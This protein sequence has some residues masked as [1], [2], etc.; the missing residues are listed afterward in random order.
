MERW[1]IHGL[2]VNAAQGYVISK[3]DSTQAKKNLLK[4][5]GAGW[6][7]AAALDLYHAFGTKTQKPEVRKARKFAKILYGC[8]T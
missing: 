4:V 5:H 2:W 1:W 8:R 3:G 7:A 6:A